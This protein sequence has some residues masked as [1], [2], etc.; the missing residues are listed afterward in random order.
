MLLRSL[1]K[2]KLWDVWG[3]QDPKDPRN[4]GVVRSQGS[5]LSHEVPLAP[6]DR[7]S[8]VTG[9]SRLATR[10]AF[11]AHVAVLEIAPSCSGASPDCPIS[12]PLAVTSE[13]PGPV[14]APAMP[15]LKG[16]PVGREK[17][18]SSQRT[19]GAAE[20]ILRH[21]SHQHSKCRKESSKQ[22]GE[23]DTDGVVGDGRTK[24][25]HREALALFL[26]GSKWT[27]GGDLLRRMLSR[28]GCDPSL[29]GSGTVFFLSSR[30]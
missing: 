29:G 2:S 13:S 26:P 5:N 4:P 3:I 18:N 30:S 16:P 12:L 27:R 24:C 21:H 14:I 8:R 6:F 9:A 20:L 19:R 17:R 25:K 22:D 28:D 10:F 11:A 15:M 1:T 23:H 7:E